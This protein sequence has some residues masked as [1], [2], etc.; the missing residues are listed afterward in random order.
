MLPKEIYQRRREHGKTP[1]PIMLVIVNYIVC[2]FLF[3]VDSKINW[4]FWL[5]LALLGVYNY[6]NIRRNRED[7]T[8]PYIIGYL[9]SFTGIVFLYIVTHQG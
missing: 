6:F 7:Y 3:T 1:S 4:F 5:T 8:R 9:V 2:S